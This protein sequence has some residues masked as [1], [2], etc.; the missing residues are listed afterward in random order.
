MKKSVFT[1][2]FLLVVLVQAFAQSA[3]KTSTFKDVLNSYLQLKNALAEDN[4]KIAAAAGK[5]LSI[6]VLNFN[7]S[8]LNEDQIKLFNSLEVDMNKHATHIGNNIGNIRHQREHFSTL[9]TEI[10]QLAKV[11]GIQK[12][13]YY[14]FCP[15][16]NEKGG[17]WVSEMKTIQNPYFGKSMLN[18][19]EIK[20]TLN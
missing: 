5:T 3:D 2:Y 11:L 4:D 1:V 16:Y 12:Q 6:A 9:S 18:C 20:E 15:M 17:Y 8:T 13:V 14:S 10:Y 19:G 7:K